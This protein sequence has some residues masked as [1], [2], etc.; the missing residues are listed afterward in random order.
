ME[1][2]QIFIVCQVLGFGS[3]QPVFHDD[4]GL[5]LF[6]SKEEA[7][8]EIQDCLNEVREAVSKGDMS[9]EYERDDYDILP[10]KIDG[11]KIKCEHDGDIYT[12]VRTDDDW[13]KA[14]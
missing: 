14:N 10:A 5:M 13:T 12:M 8:T 4:D 11:D 7:E 2:K 3:L 6:D 1:A 9:D